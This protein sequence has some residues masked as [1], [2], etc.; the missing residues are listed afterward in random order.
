FYS[1]L[2]IP[3]DVPSG[4]IKIAY[5]RIL[6]LLHPDKQTQRTDAALDRTPTRDVDVALLKEAYTTLSDPSSRA[7]YDNLLRRE[8]NANSR[9]PRP[10]QVVSLEEFQLQAERGRG[11]NE[12]L[13]WHYCCRCGG[14]YRITEDDME[15][16]K[17]LVGCESCSEVIWVGYE[18]AEEDEGVPIGDVGGDEEATATRY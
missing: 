9:G 4:D 16:G 1:L 11:E 3:R 14:T 15:S 2:R 6:L 8:A 13:E 17:H 7:A 5:H 12:E 18:V 10:A